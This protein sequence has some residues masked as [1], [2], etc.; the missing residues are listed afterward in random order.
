MRTRSFQQNL[1]RPF[2]RVA[3]IPIIEDFLFANNHEQFVALIC[4]N[5]HFAMQVSTAATQETSPSLIS[6]DNEGKGTLKENP[7]II[8]SDLQSGGFLRKEEL[9]KH[10][11]QEEEP[12]ECKS[13]E[14]ESEKHK[15]KEEESEECKLT[16][17]ESEECKVTEEESEDCKFKEE[18]K[19][20]IIKTWELMEGLEDGGTGHTSEKVVDNVSAGRRT[21]SMEYF[22][23]LE[24]YDR[25]LAGSKTSLW[26]R[27]SKRYLYYLGPKVLENVMEFSLRSVIRT[28]SLPP[29]P[30]NI[31]PIMIDWKD[32]SKDDHMCAL[33]SSVLQADSDLRDAGNVIISQEN[34]STEDKVPENTSRQEDNPF[35]VANER[36]IYSA[37]SSLEKN[38][39]SLIDWKEE[40]EEVRMCA[41]ESFVLQADSDLRDKG[42][43]IVNQEDS[44]IADVV[45]ENI[46]G[47]G[48]NHFVEANERKI[49]LTDIN[50]EKDQSTKE[51]SSKR[52]LHERAKLND[53]GGIS[54]SSTPS[55]SAVGSLRDWLS[56]GGHLYSPGLSTTPS[57]GSYIHGD[58]RS[59][60]ITAGNSEQFRLAEAEIEI[61]SFSA[62]VMDQ[63]TTIIEDPSVSSSSSNPSVSA[64]G[65]ENWDTPLF[66]PELLASFEKALEQLSNEEK[67]VLRL[68]DDSSHFLSGDYHPE[69]S[70][71]GLHDSSRVE[72]ISIQSNCPS[73][74][75]EFSIQI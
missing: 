40:S 70:E 60:T 5:N 26:D 43:E 65:K 29:K 14:E 1:H 51:N 54:I 75:E 67:S 27:N 56:S 68:I 74:Q 73:Q 44:S 21:K 30:S 57:F 12:E 10:Q 35:F 52:S 64:I 37:D 7:E 25:I 31:T 39:S 3:A 47:Q 20:E 23:T 8:M 16:E 71:D 18:N 28:D 38:L 34:S 9:E 58:Q 69:D 49:Y 32:E 6:K 62:R 41:L 45:P 4:K 36:K 13:T 48:N 50:L 17:E 19:P 66:D 22:H 63:K 42:N 46:I 59:S 2:P 53:I 61:H 33:E 24:Q 55:F 11:P 72:D 15:T